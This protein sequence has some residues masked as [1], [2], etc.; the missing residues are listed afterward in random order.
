MMGQVVSIEEFRRQRLDRELKKRLK[1]AQDDLARAY[2][3]Q[4][5]LIDELRRARCST[6][7]EECILE[8]MDRASYALIDERAD[9]IGN[10]GRDPERIHPRPQEVGPELPRFLS[11]D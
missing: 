9:R 10:V 5:D 3:A 2:R 11:D 7:S 6:R 8:M 1:A 4:S